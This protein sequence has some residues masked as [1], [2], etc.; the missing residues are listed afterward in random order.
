MKPR[1]YNDEPLYSTR[2]L[3]FRYGAECY[4][5]N[6][7]ANGASLDKSSNNC[8][9]PCAGQA[10]VVC[11]GP[12]ALNLFYNAGNAANAQQSSSAPASQPTGQSGQSGSGAQGN[13]N[14]YASG[15]SSAAGSAP[16]GQ[17]GAGSGSGQGGQGG[18]GQATSTSSAA[19]SGPTM[20]TSNLPSGWN[21]AGGG[22]IQEVAN[23]ALTGA[24]YSSSSMTV[25]SCLSFCGNRG[26]KYA[27]IEYGAECYCGNTLANGASLDLVSGQCYMS[28]AGDNT[29]TGGGPNASVP[30]PQ[31]QRDNRQF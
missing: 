21:V 1:L 22:C 26:Y 6:S 11:G 17:A 16:T 10:N 5:G 15:V 9:M 14:G 8:N 4:C 23:R 31:R 25:N 7:L 20:Q 30:S 18:Q 12:A 29:V 19:A 24:A 3:T 2:K 28:A 27:G 13:G